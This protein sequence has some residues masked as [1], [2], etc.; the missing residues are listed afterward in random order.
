MADIV[1][2]ATRSRMMSG[3][4]ARN[5]K[6]EVAV[7]SFLHRAGLRFRLHSKSLP[8]T[9]DLVLPRWHAVVFVHG[10][11]WH[12]HPGCS[13]AY[14]PKSNRR[15]WMTKF[16]MN[17]ARDAVAIAALRH[18]GWRVFTVWECQASA[19]NLRRLVAAIR[20]GQSRVPR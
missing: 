13:K 17:I 5:T 12:R 7:R 20:R 18:A 1:D 4:R 14:T 9:P 6:P 11:F 3:I 8:G 16:R 15:F 2:R 19:A 10:C